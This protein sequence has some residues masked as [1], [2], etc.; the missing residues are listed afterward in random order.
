M[1][2]PIEVDIADRVATI[3]IN[4]PEVGNAL[5][6]DAMRALALAAI[7]VDQDADVRAVVLTARGKLFCAGGDVGSFAAAGAG[8]PGLL[9]EITADLNA[10][11]SRLARMDKP[12][13]VAVNGAA[14][15]AG[16]GLALLGDIV[17]AS[18]A[19]SFTTAYTGIG[20]SADGGV[21]WLLPRLIGLRAAQELT[22]LNTRVKAQDALAMGLVTRV[23]AP[24]ALEEE[25]RSVAVALAAGPAHATAA[26]RALLLHGATASLETHLEFESREISRLAGTPEAATLISAFA[27]RQ[28]AR[29]RASS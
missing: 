1:T 29:A 25:A 13:V 8:L 9:E 15:G 16:M 3:T 21:S 14:A 23:V 22:M 17:I 2:Q 19:A 11:V 26:M 5:D 18:S 24:E 27:E 6:R 7:R 4:R 20:L 28:A 10:A 12:L